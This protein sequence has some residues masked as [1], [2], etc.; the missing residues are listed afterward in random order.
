MLKT[1]TSTC[2]SRL[3]HVYKRVETMMTFNEKTNKILFK[4]MSKYNVSQTKQGCVGM[5]NMGQVLS[6]NT[7]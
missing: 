5:T 6:Y 7:C 2:F 1:N 4:L 3:S